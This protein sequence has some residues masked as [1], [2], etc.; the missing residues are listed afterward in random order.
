[1]EDVPVPGFQK[2]WADKQSALKAEYPAL[3]NKYPDSHALIKQVF[4]VLRDIEDLA[5]YTPPVVGESSDWTSVV[6][7]AEEN[8]ANYCKVLSGKTL[9]SALYG[10]YTVTLNALK[11]ILQAS[12]L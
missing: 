8:R 11:A 9:F 7:S 3:I 6:D 2:F 10:T 5:G 12:T 4:K 1:M